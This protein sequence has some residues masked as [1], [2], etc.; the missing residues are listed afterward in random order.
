MNLCRFGEGGE[1]MT[2]EITEQSLMPEGKDPKLWM[3]KCRCALHLSHLHL[4]P[5]NLLYLHLRHLLSSA[6]D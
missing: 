3:V 5:L 1:A 6:G 4:L 2:K